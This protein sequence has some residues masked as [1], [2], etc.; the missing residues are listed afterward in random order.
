MRDEL[1]HLWI[2]AKCHG[3][4]QADGLRGLLATNEGDDWRSL[5]PGLP[6]EVF[7]GAAINVELLIAVDGCGLTG[8]DPAV[9][10]VAPD[11][12]GS[13]AARLPHAIEH[14]QDARPHVLGLGEHGVVAIGVHGNLVQQ[15]LGGVAAHADA[16]DL[17]ARSG[18]SPNNAP[19]RPARAI[20]DQQNTG[21]WRTLGGRDLAQRFDNGLL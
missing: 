13:P 4:F 2:H 21:G 11:G 10:L 5:L 18:G 8:V 20:G 14:G 15:A 9:G 3:Q 16:K 19:V 1:G 12:L 6:Q 7:A 17:A